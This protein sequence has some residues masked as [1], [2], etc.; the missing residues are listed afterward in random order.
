MTE[1][2]R[3]PFPWCAPES[4]KLRQ[5]SLATGNDFTD[6][7]KGKFLSGVIYQM[8]GCLVLHCGKCTRLA[9]NRGLV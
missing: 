9:K 6:F 4:L 1:Q 3:V 2:R 5:F 7:S 8:S